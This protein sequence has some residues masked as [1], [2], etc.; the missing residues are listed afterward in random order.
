MG[1]VANGDEFLATSGSNTTTIENT[2]IGNNET[3]PDDNYGVGYT[4]FVVRDAGGASAA[5]ENE[6]QTIS[7][8]NSATYKWTVS[9]AFTSAVGTGDAIAI[10]DNSIPSTTMMSLANR[11]LKDLGRIELVDST[12]LTTVS[13]V[14]GYDYTLPIVAKYSL[15]RVEVAQWLGDSYDIV[16][17]RKITP[18]TPN[19]TGLLTLP[20][21]ISGLT[22]KLWYEGV[23]PTLTAY[24]SVISET[25]DEDLAIK[26][27]IAYALQW[28]NRSIGGSQDYWLQ[29]EN[30]AWSDFTEA[31]FARPVKKSQKMPRLFS[32]TG[33]ASE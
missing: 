7:A 21:M 4:A 15:R 26:G 17:S 16:Y 25:V 29:S 20:D 31:K 1:K 32:L 22:I 19:A 2:L 12:S 18:S 30:K 10:A 14:G 8:Y 27:L 9:S 33:S 11:M 28:Y 13:S 23:H 6:F 5:P 24:N 3:Q